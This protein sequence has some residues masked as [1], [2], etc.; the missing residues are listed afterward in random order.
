MP[1]KPRD[2]PERAQGRAFGVQGGVV[3]AGGVAIPWLRFG[4][5][6]AT[7]ISAPSALV[8]RSPAPVGLKVIT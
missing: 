5:S 3:A 4:P 8:T 6:R 2:S 1:P 7:K